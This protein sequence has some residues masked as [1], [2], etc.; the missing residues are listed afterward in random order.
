MLHY[1]AQPMRGKDVI[2]AVPHPFPSLANLAARALN[3]YHVINKLRL[4]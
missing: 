4:K 2:N 1:I 3:K